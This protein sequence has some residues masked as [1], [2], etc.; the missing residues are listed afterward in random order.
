MAKIIHKNQPVDIRQI[1][2]D[3]LDSIQREQQEQRKLLE[4]LQAKFDR[5]FGKD[6][7]LAAWLE[8]HPDTSDVVN[9]TDHGVP[10]KSDKKKS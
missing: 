5:S 4:N 3:K 6:S 10:S 1:I 7:N 2:I 9:L 8:S